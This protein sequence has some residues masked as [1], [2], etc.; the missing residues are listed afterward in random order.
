MT[1]AASGS[2]LTGRWG[3]T[4]PDGSTTSG[5]VTGGVSADGSNMSVHLVSAGGECPPV[6][7]GVINSS[8]TQITGRY[9]ASATCGGG[10]GS[11]LN[12]SKQ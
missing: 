7:S 1:L 4:Y 9:D 8:G 11:A 6:V 2:A 3:M 5:T 10:I 12:L